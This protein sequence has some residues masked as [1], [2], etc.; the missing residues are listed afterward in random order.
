MALQASGMAETLSVQMKD[1]L[2]EVFLWDAEFELTA[3]VLPAAFYTDAGKAYRVKINTQQFLMEAVRRIAEWEEVRA[4]LP[5]DD[6]VVT[7][8]TYDKK[9]RAIT[10]RGS[11]DTLLL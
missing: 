2:Y 5:S 8:E 6:L 1:E 11:A 10:A 7:F 3:A 9:M 4:T